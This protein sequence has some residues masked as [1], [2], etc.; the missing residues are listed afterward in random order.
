MD[1]RPD[2]TVEVVAPDPRWPAAFEEERRLLLGTVDVFDRVEHIGSTAVPELPAK[3]TIDLLAVA[4]DLDAV[5]AAR[6]ALEAIGYDHR[7]GSFVERDDHLFFRKVRDG[8]RT[9]HL[10]VLRAG[11][12]QIDE[13]VRFR[14]YLVAHPDEVTAY[15]VC[16]LDLAVRFAEDR[17][18]Y[19]EEKGRYVDELMERV[20]AWQADRPPT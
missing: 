8:K 18:G 11:S 13:Y 6:P 2:H 10:H 20:R 4:A 19:V 5:L 12:P 7:P 1:R 9:H 16:K 3:P 15:A 14:D 17:M